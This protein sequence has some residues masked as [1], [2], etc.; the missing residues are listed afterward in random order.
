MSHWRKPVDAEGRFRAAHD[1]GRSRDAPARPRGGLAGKIIWGVALACAAIL[2]A[3]AALATSGPWRCGNGPLVNVNGMDC[4]SV[5][6]CAP[7]PNEA[8]WSAR[9]GSQIE[10]TIRGMTRSVTID[11]IFPSCDDR[12]QSWACTTGCLFRATGF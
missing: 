4:C 6:D 1:L 10:V 2:I 11:T 5:A 3:M 8:A 12:G 9:V 7:V